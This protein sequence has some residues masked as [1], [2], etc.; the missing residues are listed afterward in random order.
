VFERYTQTAR[1][2]IF[3]ARYVAGRVGSKEI[4]TEHLLLG[5]LS[6]DNSLARRFFGSPWAAEAICKRIE[7]RKPVRD[8]VVGPVEIPL[9]G[10]GKRVLRFAAEE[11]DSGFR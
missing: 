10:A 8:K 2:V 9:S 11:A 6:T 7:Q 4:D 1:R 5:S 3:A